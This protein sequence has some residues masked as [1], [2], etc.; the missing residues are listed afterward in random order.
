MVQCRDARKWFRSRR[1]ISLFLHQFFPNMAISD[2]RIDALEP[3]P[4]QKARNEA[5]NTPAQRAGCHA[6][7]G[8]RAVG[9]GFGIAQNCLHDHLASF[10][11]VLF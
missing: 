1:A 4:Y 5:H 2:V 3:D 10:V 7:Q 11:L 8:A 9:S 6:D